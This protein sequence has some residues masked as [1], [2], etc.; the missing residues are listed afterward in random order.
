MEGV[1]KSDPGRSELLLER[2][3]IGKATYAEPRRARTSERQRRNHI[4]AI[5]PR[6]PAIN[7]AGVHICPPRN[8]HGKEKRKR[9][10]QKAGSSG[11]KER[12]RARRLP[13]GEG[14][15]KAPRDTKEMEREREERRGRRNE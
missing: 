10:R 7:S 1:G 11:K 3:G 6:R 5:F 4:T 2:R 13:K 9:K 14:I 15:R 8:S 12:E